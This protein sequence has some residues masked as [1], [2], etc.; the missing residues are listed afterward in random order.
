[1]VVTSPSHLSLFK[2]CLVL[3][4]PC[5]FI[6]FLQDLNSIYLQQNSLDAGYSCQTCHGSLQPHSLE[7]QLFTA[8][9]YL[10]SCLPFTSGSLEIKA[11]N[12]SS[13]TLRF[14][15]MLSRRS[16]GAN[17]LQPASKFLL[18]K[19]ILTFSQTYLRN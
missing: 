1:M 17:R 2:F 19:P 9:N 7:T 3:T 5:A 13:P 16:P 4:S 11:Q 6:L 18:S 15:R 10:L 14:G 8:H 12:L